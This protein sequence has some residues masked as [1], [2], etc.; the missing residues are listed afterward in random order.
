MTETPSADVFDADSE[1]ITEI[2]PPGSA[3]AVDLR[4]L[5]QYRELLFL[6]AWRDATVRYK[7][8]V[9]GVGWALIQPLLM[10][11]I[12]TLVFGRFAK[13]PSD[14][15]PYA[16]FTL[17]ALLP[18][19]Y[20]SRS[21][22]DSSNSLVGA[23]HLLTKIYFPRL[24]LPL[25]KVFS[26]LIDFAVAFALLGVVMIWYRVVPSARIVM[27]PAFMLLAM[28]TALGTGLWLTALNVKYRDV[29]FVVPFLLQFW[30]YASPVAYSSSIVPPQWQWLYGL[31]PMV[32]VVDGFR[33]ALLAKAPPN[34]QS[35]LASVVIVVVLLLSGLY[36]FR[37]TERTFADV[38]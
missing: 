19:N 11:T 10:M 5:W 33:W 18:W 26:G 4:E 21:L 31:N 27:L 24:V 14:G 37:R 30:M 6:L 7:Q 2:A 29:G 22:A 32:G 3:L 38:I 23:S 17:T 9:V 12:F 16:V 13:L 36:Y 28:L 15:L 20:F 1:P 8:S 25:S 35:L 34:P